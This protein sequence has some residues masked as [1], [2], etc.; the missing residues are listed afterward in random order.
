MNVANFS[1]GLAFKSS[2]NNKNS[3]SFHNQIP[4]KWLN[5]VSL[6]YSSTHTQYSY[7]N[8]CTQATQTQEIP[9]Y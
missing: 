6:A 7:D 5:Y 1:K 9:V 4:S 3:F 2:I 8:V